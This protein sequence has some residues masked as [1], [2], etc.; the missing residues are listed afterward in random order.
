MGQLEPIV[1]GKRIHIVGQC[2]S[3]AAHWLQRIKGPYGNIVFL[4]NMGPCWLSQYT[5]LICTLFLPTTTTT[6]ASW[7]PTLGETRET[8]LSL[9]T[10]QIYKR[11]SP[12]LSCSIESTAFG[13]VIAFANKASFI[14]TS[15]F[16]IYCVV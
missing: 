3:T 5:R 13:T 1:K 11:D 15:F 7:A 2:G 8:S 9:I 12:V 14:P 6:Y 10:I 16:P 4:Q